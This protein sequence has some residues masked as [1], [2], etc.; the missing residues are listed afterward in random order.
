MAYTAKNFDS[1]LGLPG[2]SD[3]M[4]KNHFTLYQGYVTNV[5]KLE[6]LSKKVEM[7]TPEYAELKGRFGW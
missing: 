4:L 2:M 7:G 1:L 6:D 5:N 3:Q